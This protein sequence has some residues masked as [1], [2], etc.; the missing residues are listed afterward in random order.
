MTGTATR[1][2]TGS[3]T[4]D[5]G[6]AALSTGDRAALDAQLA[7]LSER[8][9]VWAAMPVGKR[10]RLTEA[11][12]A[13]FAAVSERWVHACV[14]GKGEEMGTHAEG[15]EWTMGPFII[16]TY[17]QELQRTLQ[18]IQRDGRP[19]FRKVRVLP[20]GQVSL[21]IYPRFARDHLLFMLRDVE[22]RFQRG[23]RPDEVPT[24]TARAYQ[25]ETQPEPGVA[26]VLGAGNVSSI[27]PTDVL[28]Q[29]FTHGRVVM[30]K[31][32][33]VNAYLLPLLEE[34]FGPLVRAGF[35]QITQGGAQAGQYLCAHPLVGNV[36]VTGSD[37]TFDA[38]VYG[39]GEEGARRRA[40][41]EPR[42][43]KPVTGELGNVTPVIVVPGPWTAADLA[44]QAENIA[45]GIVNNAGFN[46]ASTR[47]IVQ[48]ADWPLRH[49]LTRR[50]HAILRNVPARHA[51]YPGARDRWEQFTRAHPEATHAAPAVREGALPW[52]LIENVPPDAD[53]MVFSVE[54]F[55]SVVS[56]TALAAA[57]VAQ[58]LDAAVAFVNERVWGTLCIGLIVHP[59][60][61]RNASTRAALERAIDRL[62][63]GTISVNLTPNIPYGIA[64][65]PWG[66]YPG[67]E[68]HDVGSGIGWAHTPLM[69]EGVEKTVLRAPFRLP[70][71]PSWFPSNRTYAEQG[72][73][74]TAFLTHPTPGVMAR[75][76]RAVS[77]A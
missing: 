62:R 30:C 51:Y 11:L 72:R 45:A 27:A 1:G 29:L 48:H 15:Q 58:F 19:R 49:E 44:Y 43:Q 38:I 5:A 4:F 54:P 46:C 34:G 31:L 26:V 76:A 77:R 74:A 33:P 66:A 59:A 67:N 56:E 61:L 57:N 60:T 52:T 42:L 6:H 20:N 18:E 36:H 35:V 75:L 32:N 65:V 7:L 3:P 2:G 39:T 28:D 24:L 47:V 13:S 63:Y 40:A 21:S 37:K 53:D 69:L 23:V 16:L 71:R 10:L 68:P 41:R 12:V 25:P 55:C 8:A 9:P 14:T 22:V 64:R 70:L 73:L 17:L 50:V